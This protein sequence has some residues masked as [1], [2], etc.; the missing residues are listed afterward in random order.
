MV[1]DLLSA[2]ALLVLVAPVFLLF[3]LLPTL[4]EVKKPKDAGPR[5]M[6]GDISE[7]TLFVWFAPHLV[8]M[9][10]DEKFDFRL[11]P[12]LRKMLAVLPNMD[13]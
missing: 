4:L 7:T 2:S 12:G 6:M 10:V 3:M 5:V 8:N 1:L 11:G 13:A 9:E